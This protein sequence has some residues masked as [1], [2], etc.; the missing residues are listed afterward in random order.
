M[1]KVLKKYG[2]TLEVDNSKNG[3]TRIKKQKRFN[4]INDWIERR[5]AIHNKMDWD[6]ADEKMFHSAAGANF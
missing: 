3:V 6:I 5:L 1:H 4:E 2:L